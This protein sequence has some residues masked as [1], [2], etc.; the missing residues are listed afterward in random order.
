M[1]GKQQ[2]KT[3]QS[4]GRPVKNVIEP[5]DVTPEEVAKAICLLADKKLREKRKIKN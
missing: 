4:L 3:K 2:H 5:I 1:K